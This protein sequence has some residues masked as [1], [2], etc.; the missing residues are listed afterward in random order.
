MHRALSC[1]P[2]SLQETCGVKHAVCM[3]HG[4][5]A[6]CWV[7]GNLRF[8]PE[9][10]GD[11]RSKVARL[12]CTVVTC[13]GSTA[14]IC[15]NAGQ[16]HQVTAVIPARQWQCWCQLAQQFSSTLS[17]TSWTCHLH[18][19]ASCH[20]CETLSDHLCQLSPGV[21]QAGS[22]GAL[23]CGCNKGL[24][25]CVGPPWKGDGDS[26]LPPPVPTLDAGRPDLPGAP[27]PALPPPP[28]H[29]RSRLLRSSFSACSALN[30][31][32]SLRVW[33]LKDSRHV[34]HEQNTCNCVTMW[35][36]EL[37]CLDK[38]I[39]PSQRWHLLL[40]HRP[41]RRCCFQMVSSWIVCWLDRVLPSAQ[42]VAWAAWQHTW[43]VWHYLQSMC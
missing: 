37:P 12:C 22:T 3:P 30:I 1:G 17:A 11:E 23:D 18:D 21:T 32:V 20:P 27:P 8:S 26:C 24:T 14:S 25:I 16:T 40:Q 9:L 5:T 19:D 33:L 7:Q 38:P 34:Q 39:K 43:A 15:R 41:C 31:S 13:R 35:K 42:N 36:Q 4:Y 2:W 29:A 10:A 6:A 28:P